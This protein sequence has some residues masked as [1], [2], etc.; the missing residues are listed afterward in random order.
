MLNTEFL[1]RVNQLKADHK[2]EFI[3]FVLAEED[4]YYKINHE[5][6]ST[7]VYVFIDGSICLYCENSEWDLRNN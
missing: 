3:C 2:K 7:N 5:K 6:T 4:F 1:K